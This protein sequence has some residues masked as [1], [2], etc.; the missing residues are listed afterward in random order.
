L[1]VA[2]ESATVAAVAADDVVVRKVFRRLIW[3]LFLLFVVSFLDRIGNAGAAVG[4]LV[5]G[6][7]RPA[8]S[9]PGFPSSPSC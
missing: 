3:F 9:R 5:V 7:F 1:S 8:G 2:V 4:P 6:F